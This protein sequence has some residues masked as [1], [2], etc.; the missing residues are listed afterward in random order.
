MI[1]DKPELAEK[2]FAEADKAH[3]KNDAMLN[4]RNYNA[5]LRKKEIDSTLFR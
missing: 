3:F 1:S 4:N 5:I 2:D